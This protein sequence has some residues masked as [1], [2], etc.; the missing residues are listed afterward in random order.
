MASCK[1]CKGLTTVHVYQ[2]SLDTYAIICVDLVLNPEYVP[3]Y[4][5]PEHQ[6][7]PGQFVVWN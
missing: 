6:A 3:V 4:Y 5:N 7:T 2:V 1:E